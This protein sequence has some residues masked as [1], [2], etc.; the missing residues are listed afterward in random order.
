MSLT[1]FDKQGQAHMVDVSEKPSSSRTA[2]AEGLVIMR[3]DTLA[4]AQGG[5]AKGDVMGVA[6][7]AGIMAAKRTADLIPLCH[8]LPL[9]KVALDLVPDATLPGIRITATV[10]TTGQTGVEM[11]ALT[12]VSVAC[13]TVYDMLKAAEKSM[14]I[15][16][17]RLLQKSG[18]K[19]GD[20]NAK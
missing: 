11:E 14:R 1:H 13:L 17:I 12:A 4:L 3:P 18:G 20:Y 8:P 10:R 19:S 15:E 7:L 2:I 16:G 9:S 5:A 6:R